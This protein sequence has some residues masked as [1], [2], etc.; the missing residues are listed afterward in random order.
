MPSPLRALL[1]L[2]AC[3][4]VAA[5]AALAQGTQYRGPGDVVLPA[6]AGSSPGIEYDLTTWEFWW[7]FHKDAYLFAPTPREEPDFDLGAGSP[8]SPQQRHPLP[9]AAVRGEI[10]P[11]L[12]HVLVVEQQRDLVAASM[13]A[14]AKV[15]G[16]EVDASLRWLLLQR[17]PSRDAQVRK[18][19]ALSLAMLAQH[20]ETL[21][22]IVADL[23]LDEARGRELCRQAGDQEAVD[24]D[25]RTY[26]LF[27]LGVAAHRS[28][29]LATKQLVFDVA[30]RC[31]AERTSL[32]EALQVAAVL[33][34]GVLAPDAADAAGGRL[35]DA[36][37]S[38]LDR[39]FS[40]AATAP[41]ARANCLTNFVQA[42]G[43]R[44]E[45][46]TRHLRQCADLLAASADD[47]PTDL[48]HC[49]AAAMAFAGALRLDPDGIA[50]AA[51]DQH[52]RD[53]LLATWRVHPDTQTRYLAMVSLGRC[54]GLQQAEAIVEELAHAEPRGRAFCALALGL[55]ARASTDLPCALATREL[56][57][58]RLQAEF[59]ATRDPHYAGALAV[60]LGLA[61]V[62][63]AA[64]VLRRTMAENVA[65]EDMAG[66]C[67]IGLALLGDS[68]SRL[69]LQAL[70]ERASRRFTFQQ[71]G[72]LALGVLGD[73]GNAKRLHSMMNTRADVNLAQLSAIARTLGRFADRR[74]VPSLRHQLLAKPD[75]DLTRAFA[76]VAL[77][78]LGDP[79]PLPWNSIYTQ[80]LAYRALV[81][82][83]TNGHTGILDFL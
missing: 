43:P 47:T 19:A 82:P 78:C 7:E 49:R 38:T 83:L 4:L 13:L 3:G 50:V 76:A 33:V 9:A 60:A 57:A 69:E 28:R 62:D 74:L 59:A 53:V 61:R 1:H 16:S 68:A 52:L 21:L 8:T 14:L 58:V 46:A 75:G 48:Q 18:V 15:H 65:K 6:G 39:T 55:C 81:L 54:G 11:A 77:G 79:E 26:A 63:A 66:Y 12:R 5:C 29:E 51:D 36:I 20:D 24:P 42:A 45:A 64:P 41:L 2:F 72:I 32:P 71:Q 35:R 80:N 73:S 22:P 31:L 44:T 25:V 17:L 67:A 37:L 34:L 27:G 70:I 10:E 40:D 56:A 23:V 30:N